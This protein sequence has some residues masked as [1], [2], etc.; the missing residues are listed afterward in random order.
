MLAAAPDLD[1]PLALNEHSLNPL[2]RATT[3]FSGALDEMAANRILSA[4]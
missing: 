1:I 3:G 2:A 4:R